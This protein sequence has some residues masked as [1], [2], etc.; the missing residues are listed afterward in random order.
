[1]IKGKKGYIGSAIMVVLLVLTV[2]GS[3][4]GDATYSSDGELHLNLVDVPGDGMYEIYLQATDSSGQEFKL[5]NALQLTPGPGIAATFAI[6]TGILHIPKLTVYGVSNSTKYEEVELELIPGSNPMRFKVKG[7]NPLQLGADDRGPMG[8]QGPQG[9]TGL[10]GPTGPPGT[11]GTNGTDG[12]NGATGATGVSA[13]ERVTQSN[14]CAAL[15][16]CSI[17]VTCT[18]TKKLL[19]GGV[20]TS[21]FTVLRPIITSSYPA[22][23]N[24]WTAIIYNSKLVNTITMEVWAICANV[25]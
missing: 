23:D 6:E 8:P 3:A 18:G 1:M 11:P 20:N 9:A 4:W 5:K 2:M 25:E 19:G 13:W 16:T 22:A 15:T 14:T 24:Q 17:S 7:V 10:S 21:G 12:T